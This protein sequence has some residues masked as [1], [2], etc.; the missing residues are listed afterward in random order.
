M[1]INEILS[2]RITY[3]VVCFVTMILGIVAVVGSVF[4]WWYGIG[5]GVLMIV[6][7]ILGVVG[8]SQSHRTIFLVSVICFLVLVIIAAIGVVLSIL[9]FFSIYGIVVSAVYCVLFLVGT[10]CGW[11]LY[12]TT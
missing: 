9:A 5:M 10:Y 12:K 8:L 11:R 2:S 7:G 4:S 6:T 3:Y 1:G